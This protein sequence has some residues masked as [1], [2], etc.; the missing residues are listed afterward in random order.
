MRTCDFKF[1]AM[2]KAA[3]LVAAILLLSAGASF[4]QQVVNLTAGSAGITLPDGTGVPMW[5]YSCGTP[6]ATVST[7]ASAVNGTTVTVAVALPVNAV[8]AYIGT[9]L[10]AGTVQGI[11]TSNTPTT[12]T[13]ASWF[14]A[15]GAFSVSPIGAA[16][17]INS[18]AATTTYTA[19]TATDT[20]LAM[21]PNAY[22]GA[23]ITVGTATGTVTGNTA[24][25]LTFSAGWAA[26]AP[27]PAASAPISIAAS[28]AVCAP[29]N[30][31]SIGGYVGAI[32]VVNGGSGYT[33]APTVVIT[34]AAG[35]TPA[36]AATAVANIQNGQVV[37]VSVTSPGIG[38]TSAPTIS[39][40]SASTTGSGATAT[41]GLWWSPVVITVP[42]GQALTINLTNNLYSSLLTGA[43]T[44]PVNPIPT[45]IM[46]VGQVGGGL[47]NLPQRTTSPSHV[48]AQGCVTWF[49]ANS[50]PGVPCTT[51]LSGATPP[52]QMDRVQSFASEVAPVL[53]G[54][55]IAPTSLT[56]SALRP[57]TYL[58]ES[59]THPSI[60]APMG[61]IGMLVVTTA[62]NVTAGTTGT[63][64]PGSAAGTSTAAIPAVSYNAEVPLEFSEIDPVQNAAV[65]A[66]VNTA[67]FSETRVWDGH[68]GACGNPGSGAAYHTCYP[69][70]VNYTPFYYLINGVAFSKPNVM[71]SV[72]G[73]SPA[74]PGAGTILVRLVNAG[75]RMHVPSIVGSQ[76]TGFTGAGA[77][78]TVSGFT[79]IAED[80]NQL[81]TA[82]APRVQTHVFMPAG[83]TFDVMVN[84]PTGTGA[85]DLPIY[86][87]DLSLSANS[88]ERDAGMLAYISSNG[89]QLPVAA[90]A[91]V[92][93]AATANPDTYS[94]VVP[95][96]AA[97]PQPP[98]TPLVVSDVSKGV[99]ANDVNVYGVAIA[100]QPTNG[101][102]TLNANGTFT[103]VPNPGTGSDIFGYCA[104]GAAPGTTGVCTTVTLGATGLKGGP[105]ANAITYNA[106]TSNFLK[107]ASP[108]VLAV[109]SDPNNLPLQVVVSSV[110]AATG[111]TINMDPNGG[112]TA[113]LPGTRTTAATATF[114]YI[115]QNSQGRESGTA[116]VTIN[117]P[118]PSNLVVNVVDAQ[119]YSN[120]NGDSTCISSLPLITDYRWIIE[121]DK[122][123]WV[124]PNC[125]T[126]SSITTPGCPTLVG[127]SGQSTIPAYSTSFHTSSMDFVAQGCTGALSCEGGQTMYDA[128]PS[129]LTFG[130]HIPAVCDVGNGACRPDTTGNGY[131]AVMPGSVHLDPSKRYYI[132]VLPGDAANPFPTYLGAPNCL[133]SPYISGGGSTG[134]LNTSCGH[135]MSG[136]PIPAACN[137][138]L[139]GCN[140]ASTAPFAPVTVKSLPT[141]LPTGKLSVMVFEDDFPL[142]GE[143][144]SGG[145]IDVLSPQEPGLGGFNIVLW[146]TYGGLGDVTGQDTYDDFNQ[147]LSNALA[148]TID[149]TTNL[150]ACPISP[151]VTANVL[152]TPTTPGAGNTPQS[153]TG[154][155]GII[156]TC[157][158]YESDGK[159]LSPLAGQALIANLMPEK[160]SV[161]AYPGADR[162]ARGEE[163]IQT[164]T[165]DGQHPHDSFI[166]IGEP[167]FFQEYGPAGYHVSIGF[168][169]PAI[170]NARHDAIC[171]GAFGPVGAC[172]GKVVG[173]VNVQRLSRTP[174]QRLYPSGSHDALAWTQ[175]WAS[176]GDPDAADFMF[177]KCDANGNFQ[178]TNVPGGNWRVTIGDQWNDQIID[179]LS[180]P[181]NVVPGQTLNMGQ[182]GIQQWQANVYTR[183]FID[184]NKNGI[185]DPGEIG[186]PLIY[187]R[188]YY[189]DGH[190]ANFLG[191]DFNG[192][193]NF[194]ETFP[195]FNWY[196]VEADSTRYK[197]T[198]IHTVYDAGG[199]ADGSP[200][201][202]N[203]TTARQCGT[204][205]DY[206][207][208]TNTFEGVPLPADL[209]VPGA[210]YCAKADC[211]DEAA[212]FA[213]GT[214][215][216]S[217]A[218]ASTGRIDPPW[219]VAEAWSGETSQGN[220][221]EFGK[222]PYAACDPA[223]PASTT[224]FCATVTTTAPGSTT[225]TVT[226]VGENGGIQGFVA[227]VS[228]RPFDS[229]AQMIQQPWEPNI[230]HVTV[231]LY[232][233]GFAADGVTPTLQLVDTT[234]TSS[235]DDWAQGFYPGSTAGTG[236]GAGLKP[237][238]NC[239]GQGTATGTNADLFFYTLFD[240]PNYLDLYN[241]MH[242]G[243][244]APV[245]PLPYN[246]QFKCYDAMHIWN[247]L[248]PAPYDGKY[249]FPSS[250]GIN[251]TTGRPLTTFG[252][253]NGVAA[254]MPG[255]NCTICVPNPDSTDA[256]RV[257]TPM[258]PPGKYVLQVMMPPGFEVY[259]EED[260][261][262]LI[263]DN[264]IAPTTQQFAGLGGSIFI[265]PDQAS[266]ASL[267]DQSGAGFNPI[268]YQNST[269][270]LG[271]AEEL[272]G[273][274]GFPG[275]QDPLW[276]CVG[277]MRIVPD[278]LSLFPLAK[279]TAPFA[280][281][282]RP[283]C[284]RKEVT[285]A[286]QMS[287]RAHFSLFTSTHIASKF[288]GVIT[289]DFTAE[290][291]PFSPQFGEKF[292]PPSLP[293]STKDYLGNEI[294]RVYS[295]QFGIYD[296]LTY[297]SWEVNPPNI[298][299]YSP[300]MMVQC[301]NDGGSITDTRPGSLT[302]GQLITDP[303]YN[304]AY[305]SFCYEEPYM[306]GLT[307]YLDTP[308]VPTQAF[309]GAGYNN[310]DCAYPDATPA[311]SEV[312]GDGL[313]PWVSAAGSNIT[314]Y[315]LGDQTVNNH[316]YSGPSASAAPFNATTV[317]RHFGFG[318]QCASPTGAGSA[319]CNTQSTVKIG[320]VLAPIVSWSDT[321]I[322]AT[323]PTG[324][325]GFGTVPPCTVQQQA[326]YASVNPP[327]GSTPG[328]A[329]CGELVITAGNGKQSVDAVTVTVG[330]KA[331]T[332]V[333]SSDTIQ[334]A[335]DAAAP[336]D[337]IMVDPTCTTGSG[338][339]LRVVSCSTT[340]V[341]NKSAAKHNEMVLMWKPVRLQGV[342]AAS[343][344]I[345][346]NTHPAGKQLNPWRRHVNCL[347]GLTLQGAPYTS[348]NNS[349]VSP[350][351]P[352]PYDATG[353]YSCPDTGW[354]YFQAQPNVPQ[355]DRQ[356]LESTVGWVASLNGNMAELL[357]EPSLMGAYEGAGITVL[358]KGLDFHGA[359]PWSD[360]FE[361]GAFP[362]T[363]T[364][365]TGVVSNP[366][367]PNNVP[368]GLQLGDANP[369][370]TDGANGANRFPS[371][372][373]CNPSS[374]DG[375]SVIN[376]SQGG[377][378]IFIHGWAHYLEVANNRVYNNAGTLSGGISVGQG[379]FA[380]P[381]LL[382]GT[383]NAA[384]GSCSDGT[385]FITNQHL[386]YCLQLSVNVHNNA[387]TNNSSIGDELFS[388]TLSGGGGATLCT[389]ND[390][391]KFHYNWVCGNLS[392]GEGGGIVHLG[393]IQDGAIEHNSIAF[394][395]SSNPTIPT[396]GGGIMVQG[397]PDTDPTCPGAPDVDCPPGLSDGTGHNLTINANLIQGNGADSGSGGGIRI[398]SVNGTEVSTFPGVYGI[399]AATEAPVVTI[400][401]AARAVLPAVN[402]SVTITGSSV[403]GYNG[404]FTVT[405]VGGCG[406]GG[407]CFQF[408][409]T[410]PGLGTGTGGSFTDA[411]PHVPAAGGNIA[412]ATDTAPGTVTITST[413]SPTVGDTVTIAGFTG[414]YSIYNGAH[415]VTTVPS[416][417]TFTYTGGTGSYQPFTATAAPFPTV[418]DS[419]PNQA[420]RALWNS[421]TI[422]NNIIVN[423]IAGWDGA[424]ISLQDALNV[425]IVNNT[426]AH[427]DSLATSGVITN[428][429]GT[430]QAS[431]PAGNCVM[432]GLRISC[433]QS[434]G[435][436]STGNSS[437]LRAA[438]T[439]LTITCPPG[440]ANCTGFSN[441][442]LYNNII[443]QNRSFHVG[444]GTLG[445]GTL[446]QQNLVSLFNAFTSTLAPTQ[447]STGACSAATYW[448]LGVRGDTTTAPNSGSGFA[449]SPHQSV[450]T[451]V[452]GYNGG[453]AGNV[454][455]DP[456]FVSQYCNGSRVPPECTVSAGC[457]GP[458]GYGVPPG[459]ADAVTPNP[460]FSLAPAATVDE[461]NNWINVS[462]GPLS[463][464]S[465]SVL[466]ADGKWGGGLP[467]GNYALVPSSSAIDHIPT[468]E[469]LPA[470]VTRPTTD[471][472]GNPR[473]DSE[474]VFDVG[475]V[476]SQNTGA[477]VAPRLTSISPN[478]GVRGTSVP[479]TLTGS[480]LTGTSAIN[481][482]G[483]GV[484][485]SAI[486]VVSDTTVVA[487]FTIS[488]T[489]ALGSR[490]VTVVTPNG[491]T[492]AVTFTVLSLTP[493]L[494]S[495][496]PTSGVRGRAVSVTL[497]GTNLTGGTINVPAGSGI[498]VSNVVVNA[499]GTS[500]TATFTIANVPNSGRG[501]QAISVTTPN[502]TSGTVNFRITG[503]VLTFAASGL[504][505]G[506]RTVKNG[507]VTITN[508]TSGGAN[509]GP[510]TFSA[511]PTI[512]QT[513][514][515][516]AFSIQP[517]GNCTATT[518]LNPGQNCTI[519]VRYTPPASPASV[520]STFTV[521]ATGSGLA[522]A[523]QTSQSITGN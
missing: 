148:G 145:G 152:G 280:G 45:S 74:A 402:D 518:T 31:R 386:P 338:T 521:T 464:T 97:T 337:L 363:T 457:G 18:T 341:V 229:A 307:T 93:A 350:T 463:L 319:T 481:V 405:H 9:T 39:F 174:D 403:A 420:V 204:S 230:P 130:T 89:S 156:V 480:G 66:A 321:Q 488:A 132:S 166:R 424:G 105:T 171:A 504:G 22:V 76:T 195:L 387:I 236:T 57:G 98:C 214:P 108:G 133:N 288:T 88:S 508:T 314:I 169:N 82:A 58:L 469:T 476:E 258:L 183:T 73:T 72:F 257:G 388:A 479:V 471:F 151:G 483:A 382:G 61:L 501:N 409:G 60:Q 507:T 121:E 65:N 191:T 136:A 278:Y 411:T 413:L 489:A 44:T 505:G 252:S 212:S 48:N 310:T 438:M 377:G 399:T 217:F 520:T 159:T 487:T 282:T 186:I 67:G 203:G 153:Q 222:A 20:S 440:H 358:G 192:V 511:S 379:E 165:L 179:G 87:R 238:M 211:K 81:P 383:A 78:A 150:D 509:A 523:T 247:Q 27:A 493:T 392:S 218:G 482:S 17:A 404:T 254:N 137:I 201:C 30:T 122:T 472:F 415:I 168:A 503:A 155:T 492:N 491:T 373:I 456:R 470:G 225:P 143:Q 272:S 512:T 100:T 6:V 285:L 395:E 454:A 176:L 32:G 164:N 325:P 435:V 369:L 302:F 162:I 4:G 354:N 309:V 178:F 111:L 79:L 50:A 394:N 219:V 221:I 268:N 412:N 360:G 8:N 499:A 344:V 261:N 434:A 417:G 305:S 297:S 1:K 224:N 450:L 227:Y 213:L 425:N 286:N 397:T 114:T 90:G 13:V 255:T 335:I 406:G 298:T 453:G 421:V 401:V 311:I 163:W 266:V 345:D 243:G 138:Y 423:N 348:G 359:A 329:L 84:A 52:V 239:P 194:N 19:T 289:D 23:T 326:Q 318:T 256:Y 418:T 416:V 444:V 62:P 226:K 3:A 141:P 215:K 494:T 177:T 324:G 327:P 117:F 431:A 274:P 515:T 339:T 26:P 123:F 16:A 299:G 370:C 328:P 365:L 7:T 269:T 144:D 514:G 38:Y 334:S 25:T 281:A 380:P 455:G 189:R 231:N 443:Y 92:F 245:H 475:A 223:Q 139:A 94:A 260:K 378:G 296:G 54:S 320:G 498:T 384:P 407:R 367:G 356:P 107:I 312:D 396:N 24:T 241:S 352:N 40:T 244:A 346:A 292:S 75:L 317:S 134:V 340:G 110:S 126:N 393:E 127:P 462:W 91:G 55:T 206:N 180:T 42:S 516:G 466:G 51:D 188:V 374:I 182:L 86:A 77:S 157:P 332:H 263:G 253:T 381:Y 270:G 116:T 347:F 220:W 343:T 146:D 460:I 419:N 187:T 432:G 486:G 495:I 193:A 322:V 43:G 300:T 500:M 271:L 249:S 29:L 12:L 461:G 519:N 128:N 234:Q 147:P 185:P 28:S 172:T 71:A 517:G 361:P 85:P 250:L 11:V 96:V 160:F 103:Y 368:G 484:T 385:G 445:T 46:I 333:L 235:W 366:G 502:G 279:E 451:S 303:L 306:P 200:S 290:F 490:N 125:T 391:Y 430:P 447:A 437:L 442:A 304:P 41:A 330:G 119:S 452:S 101:V 459:I 109:D 202:G 53:T 232:Q 47:G 422:T 390:Y 510:T 207:F 70:A 129:S 410:T 506:G 468:N 275:F 251:A 198:G 284:D 283:L 149:P 142:N 113:S 99:I 15:S 276:P 69:P 474:T 115:A 240:Q 331:P 308:V 242:S 59:A 135:T 197:T 167:S 49:I 95:C 522:A 351:N 56:W 205:T 446:N 362:T 349:T 37:S 63:A 426:I 181:A 398:Q 161:Q 342:G 196:V 449:L 428:S 118:A 2:L 294:S 35:N 106:H 336:G 102:V 408:L 364:L 34:P 496:S 439:G 248:Q 33:A 375:L 448:D 21:V 10:T 277:E 441:P 477:A 131:T 104:N 170:I 208:L 210:V 485:V 497:T 228:T 158:K 5:G 209:S 355:I 301:M 36:T 199:P 273:V 140:S 400:R 291:D 154:I 513:S 372:F 295:D 83:K 237:Y 175:C 68:V 473:P 264:F 436:T 427:N 323:V 433:P 184:D 458:R 287:V 316:G 478:T 357:Q 371:N 353:G 216:P 64:Y 173:Q 124:D 293:V 376:S 467:L 259:K 246:S 190:N 315:A 429:I 389:G 112:F 465:P 80:G 265:M 313:G 262:L 233:E 14:P 414:V 267:Y 120:C